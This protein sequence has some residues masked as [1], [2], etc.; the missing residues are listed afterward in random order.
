MFTRTQSLSNA[1]RQFT[2]HVRVGTNIISEMFRLVETKS[3]S[4]I[5]NCTAAMILSSFA[6]IITK[7]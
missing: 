4:L 7:Q 3:K 1:F 5:L 6:I 2:V